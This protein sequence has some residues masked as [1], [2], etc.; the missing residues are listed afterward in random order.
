M[1]RQFERVINVLG[2]EGLR[3]LNESTV[4]VIGLGG[5][6]GICAESLARSGVGTMI[7]ADFDVVDPSNLNRQILATAF[8]VGQK[9][10][11][12]MKERLLEICPDLNVVTVDLRITETNA[13]VLFGLKPDYVI[14]AIDSLPAKVEIWKQCQENGVPFIAS[15]GMARRLD[16]TK[17][18]ETVL[19]KTTGDPMARKLRYMARNKGIDL[20]IPVVFSTEEAM[21]V[22]DGVL[23]S[24]MFVPSAA[25]LALASAC[26][27]YLTDKK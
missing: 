25:G 16:P 18:R 14:D 10:T 15:L 21:E 7:L 27:R 20:N 4:M 12:A 11:E 3:K 23:G 22:K 1:D 6:G 19:N 17:V 2:E 9:K 13:E 8:T 5:V 24:M 26:V